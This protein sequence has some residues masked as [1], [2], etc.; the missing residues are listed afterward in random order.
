MLDSQVSDKFKTSVGYDSQVFDSQ[1][2]DS[3]VNDKYKTDEGYHAVPPP[4][5]GNF[6][7]SK[8]DL[9]LADKDAYIFSESVT[10]V[11]AVA[12]SK[13]N[14]SKS[15]PKSVSEPLIKDWISNSENENETEESVKKV[16]NY[17]QAE[18]P[19]KNSQSPRDCDYYEKKIVEKPVWNNARRVNHQNS[20]RRTHPH[21][22]RNFVPKAVLM[23]SSFKTLNTT[24]QNSS[25]AAV[26]V[27]TARP[28]NTAYPRPI[29]NCARPVSNVFKR[30]HSH[31]SRPFNKFTTNKHIN[32]NEKVNTVRGNVT[33]VRPKVVGN[34][35][36]DFK[37]KGV[38]YSGCSRH[39]TGNRSYLTDY[40]E[41]DRGFVTFGGSTKG[42][43]ITRKD[44]K[45][46]DESHVLLKVPR[47]DNMYSVDLKKVIPQGGLTCLFAKAIP[48]E[49]NLWHMRLGHILLILDSNRHGR[50]KK[51]DTEDPG[52]E[53][54]ASG[55]DS[56]VPSTEEPREDQRVN[57]ELDAINAVDLKT[58]IE[59]PNDL[60]MPELED[61]VYS[62]DDEDV[63]VECKKQTMV[64]NS[65]TEAEYV[66]ALSCCG[67]VLWIQTQ[68]LD[69]GQKLTAAR[70]KLKR[71][72]RH[73]LDYC[74]F[75][76]KIADS[77][78]KVAF[79]AKPTESDE[80]EQILDFL[81]ANPIK[82]AL[83]VNP[84][85]YT[86]CIEQFWATTKV[87]TVNG[88]V[89]LQALGD[90]KKVIITETSGMGKTFSET[91]L[92]KAFLS[93][94]MEKFFDPYY[95]A[96]LKPIVD[97][98]ANEENVP[99]FSNDPL[100]SGEDSLKL[101]DLMEICTKLQQRVLDL[102]NT[103]LLNTETQKK[104]LVIKGC[105]PNRG[106]KID[107]L[108]QDAEVTI[109]DE[110]QRSAATTI[111]TKEITLAQALAEL[112]SVKPKVVVQ[113]PVQSI[114]TT[115][116]ST[117]PK[118]KSITFR[119]PDESTTRPTLTP[120]LQTS[121]KGKAKMDRP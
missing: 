70:R 6:M 75:F 61:I 37:D 41:I 17:K 48:D 33:T 19:R 14:I 30:A 98:A 68:L 40:V 47:K 91:T 107:A 5:T 88:E 105:M 15:K 31:V 18:Y 54:A 24:S 62:D 77:H 95:S 90:G 116:P 78:N 43:K 83:T 13:A 89:Q 104:V 12:T 20:Q 3:Q 101:N 16:K 34:P 93:P 63:G 79:L 4:Y 66:A 32:F 59:L 7:P 36:Q 73:K 56:E 80:F 110:T 94:S 50:K 23:K 76:P 92:Y 11:P 102:E 86:S 46:T 2:F 39:M 8:P 42:G 55:K 119:D 84:T 25:R 114:T 64:A 49:S 22:K 106:W 118:A 82:Y 60:N 71:G 27:N 115:A 96:I 28:I 35:Q 52:N 51:I 45:L 67:Q 111:N 108:D 81:N 85:I 74:R 103:E 1:V 58:S 112:R 97:E 10:S 87:K 65:T 72:A 99:T 53:N 100:L 9:V 109:G 113:E 21:S 69:Y 57:Q 26:S 38:I 44:F 117:I 29:V 121:D 120:Y